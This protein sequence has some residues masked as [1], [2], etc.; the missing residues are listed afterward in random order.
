MIRARLTKLSDNANAMRT[1]SVEGDA[2]YPPEVGKGFIIYSEPLGL[3][4]AQRF[5]HTS[6]VV[7]VTGDT[8]TTTSGTVYRFEVLG[9]GSV[10]YTPSEARATI[11][12]RLQTLSDAQLEETLT[13]LDTFKHGREVATYF[14]SEP[15]PAFTPDV[16]NGG[17]L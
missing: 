4:A 10:T 1:T 6:D 11:A 5:V 12:T 9:N 16:N 13:L 15:L 7:S 2:L 14:V 3:S 8:F 17:S